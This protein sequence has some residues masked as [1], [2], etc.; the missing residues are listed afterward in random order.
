MAI[1]RVH[2]T[3][4]GGAGVVTLT[5]R[6]GK[7][8]ETTVWTFCPSCA[9][10]IHAGL[11]QAY[12]AG[13][14]AAKRHPKTLTLRGQVAD[15]VWLRSSLEV[16]QVTMVKYRQDGS[17]YTLFALHDRVL[18]QTEFYSDPKDALEIFKTM[19]WRAYNLNKR[20]DFKHEYAR[21]ACYT[22]PSLLTAHA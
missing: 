3:F 10:K 9:A 6:D 19:L 20:G 1:C 15:D 14:T 4:N 22:Q 18:G 2:G 17:E 7:A 13:T 12:G 11:E 8:D 16:K 21:L 5:L